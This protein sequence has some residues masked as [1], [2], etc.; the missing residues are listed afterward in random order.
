MA[1]E[2]GNGITP[3][4]LVEKKLAEMEAKDENLKNLITE[5]HD[6]L[7][8]IEMSTR[9]V[10]DKAS[11][12]EAGLQAFFKKNKKNYAWKEPRF[13]GIAYHVQKQEDVKAV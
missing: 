13:K 6:G 1:T 7:L 9:T 2:A 12:D 11:T 8:L 10:W 3:E 5:Y 4:Q